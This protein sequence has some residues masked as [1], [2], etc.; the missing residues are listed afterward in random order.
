MKVIGIDPGTLAMGISII[1]HTEQRFELLHLQTLWLK[2][3]DDPFI[4]LQK[5]QQAVKTVCGIY[6]PQVLSIEMPFFGKNA[7]VMLKLGRVQGVC[8]A[9]CLDF[10]EKVYEYAPRK[11]KL[12]ITGNGNAS[13]EQVAY[14]VQTMLK[15][16]NSPKKSLLEELDVTDATA[17]AITYF[18]QQNTVKKGSTSPKKKTKNWSAFITENPDRVLPPK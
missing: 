17:A 7:Q 14:F 2:K 11:I 12:A 18:L 13:K 1:E 3:Y 16:N 8:I 4:K 10:V 15:L 5:V 6:T 9:T